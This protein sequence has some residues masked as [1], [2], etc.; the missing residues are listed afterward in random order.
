MPVEQLDSQNIVNNKEAL[1]SQKKFLYEI[2][3]ARS[4]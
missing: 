4:F 2:F 3:N 1:E